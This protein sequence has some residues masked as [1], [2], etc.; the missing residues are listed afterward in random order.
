MVRGVS[1]GI[2]IVAEQDVEV[3][4]IPRKRVVK[5]LT[6]GMEAQGTV[7]QVTSFGAFVDIGVGTDGLVH[8]SELAPYRVSKVEDIIH[9]GDN[10][11]VWIKDL[12]KA[13]NRI[14]L[15]MVRPGSKTIRDFHVGDVVSGKVTRIVPFGAFVDIGIQGQEALL[16]VREMSERYVKSPENEVSVG[17]ELEVKILK[18]EP[19]RNRIDLTI[20]GLRK[21]KEESTSVPVSSTTERRRR[22]K[23]RRSKK[24]DVPLTSWQD[25]KLDVPTP[26]EFALEK[27]QRDQ[28]L[29]ER[30]HRRKRW[31]EL[32]DDEDDPITRTLRQ[33]RKR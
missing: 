16:H 19:W 24:E 20:K 17:E 3:K 2:I 29:K 28:R 25:D 32:E 22:P 11:T 13:A 18:V 30:K 4:V 9:E 21:E 5:K 6:R 33:H 12:D 31:E 10:V 8:I 7:R 26:F 14:S 27:A 23:G 15:T 1:G